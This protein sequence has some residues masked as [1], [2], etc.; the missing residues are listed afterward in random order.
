MNDKRPCVD[1][2]EI[3]TILHTEVYNNSDYFL[4]GLRRVGVGKKTCLYC[5]STPLAKFIPTKTQGTF[6]LIRVFR[7][8]G[9][10]L[11]FLPPTNETTDKD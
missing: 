6:V 7:R 5:V 4:K 9:L 8:T 10:T 1:S 3:P 11:A 2:T